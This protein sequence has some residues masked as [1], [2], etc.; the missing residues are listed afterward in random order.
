[1]ESTDF[2]HSLEHTNPLRP[3]FSIM[4][5]GYPKLEISLGGQVIQVP[6]AEIL[7]FARRWQADH[8]AQRNSRIASGRL[9]IYP[10]PLMCTSTA[11][12]DIRLDAWDW[13]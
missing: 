4:R 2:L 8:D 7:E 9:D 6:M 10:Y 13:M 1:M 11:D 5:A 12:P 3:K